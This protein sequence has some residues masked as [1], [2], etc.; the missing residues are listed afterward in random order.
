MR[1]F[2]HLG[3]TRSGGFL[4]LSSRFPSC[5]L[6]TMLTR[7]GLVS[8]V[9]FLISMIPSVCAGGGILH[10]FPP[11]LENRAFAVARPN[12]LVSKSMVTVSEK[13]I[14]TRID[15]TFL[16]DNEFPVKGL[17]LLPLDKSNGPVEVEVRVDGTRSPY[18]IVPSEEF[19]PTLKKLTTS[20]R[21]PSLLELA[22]KDVLVIRPIGMGVGGQKSFLIQYEHPHRLRGDRL[23]LSLS[24]AGERYSLGPVGEFEIGVRFTLSRTVRTVLSPT[25]HIS[26]SREA[27]HRCLIKS[28]HKDTAIR[29]DFMLLTTFAGRNLNLRVLAH[30]SPGKP[31]AFMALI[32]PPL[33]PGGS[34]DPD[35]DIV[36]LLD[37]SGSMAGAEFERAKSVAAA[38]LERLGPGDRFNVV[39]LGTGPRRLS[40][41]LM[42]ASRE[43]VLEAVRFVNSRVCEGGSDL[44]NGLMDAL[45][46]F[47]SKNRSNV[48]LL[49]GD[50]RATV[51][52]TDAET[53]IEHVDKSNAVGAR[54][55]VTSLGNAADVAL[56]DRLANTT[57]GGA[58]HLSP[59]D[60]LESTMKRFFSRISP[61]KVSDISL[62]FK[63][64]SIEDVVPYPVQDLFG[65]ESAIAFG[66]YSGDADEQAR[67]TLR[68]KG[69]TEARTTVTKKFS[70]PLVAPE[71]PYIPEIWAMRQIAQLVGKYRLNGRLPELAKKTTNLAE[72]FGFLDPLP[73][74]HDNRDPR[75]RSSTPAA[76]KLLWRF[77]T[78]CV[79]AE[80]ASSTFKRIRGKMFRRDEAGWIDTAYQP[81]MPVKD[82]AFLS[83]EYFSSLRADPQ[84]G[85]YLAVG[86]KVTVVVGGD[87]IRFGPP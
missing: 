45:E 21:D 46:L 58:I 38:G 79:P 26:V 66:R 6:S 74:S 61:P 75:V 76:A 52:V 20:M 10:I 13:V 37:T 68:G 4:A 8:A 48:V 3:K 11:K 65:T 70:L 47:V 35:R 82:V 81:N 50:G 69:D 34:K 56:L 23:D 22:G 19:F 55:F 57:R 28:R 64:A 29:H 51:G 42:P 72:E 33:N 85:A 54:I 44:Y 27:P 71:H 30:R 7:Q 59:G 63:G 67:I 49:I 53:I 86:P 60:D 31:G 18:S 9:V 77:K 36:I 39:T 14:R 12:L 40:E 1:A 16:N 83:D 62:D 32:E 78:S 41:G 43:N 24:M 17:F 73:F 84:M 87:A 80:V 15:Q 5:I 25:H 2:P